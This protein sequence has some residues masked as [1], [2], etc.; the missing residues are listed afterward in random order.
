MESWSFWMVLAW[1]LRALTL[2]ACAAPREL[3]SSGPKTP[4][5]ESSTGMA[6][7]QAAKDPMN[8]LVVEW[9]ATAKTSLEAA[10][11]RGMVVVSYLGCTLKVLERCDAGGSYGFKLLT[12]NELSLSPSCNGSPARRF[13]LAPIALARCA[14]SCSSPA[15]HPL[16]GPA[17]AVRREPGLDGRIAEFPRTG[18]VSLVDF[19]ST[20]CD[21]CKRVLPSLETLWN[22]HR[23][24]GL[25]IIGES[26]DDNP[27]LVAQ[28]LQALGITY[29]NLLD[30][31]GQVRGQYRVGPVPHSVVIDRQGACASPSPEAGATTCGAC[32]KACARP[33]GRTERNPRAGANV[34]NAGVPRDTSAGACESKTTPDTRQH[35]PPEGS[36]SASRDRRRRR[37]RQGL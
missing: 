5:V 8:P 30:T 10:S 34:P 9:P 14:L 18:R 26:T 6:T 1:L 3:A 21:S 36:Y 22:T 4:S 15:L 12:P 16:R 29:P 17:V 19:W 31:S 32:S 7:Y 25:D 20:Y 24:E 27:G 23:D 28:Q 13:S 35:G 2:P 33:C 37:D 11:Q